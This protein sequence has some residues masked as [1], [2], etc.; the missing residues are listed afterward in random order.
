MAAWRGAVPL[1]P[2]VAVAAGDAGRRARDEVMPEM[3][4][5]L[6]ADLDDQRSTPLA[7]LREAVRYPTSVLAAA[8]VPP[9]PRDEFAVRA[10]P[11]DAYNLTPATWADLDPSLTEAGIAWGAAKAFEH[12]RRHAP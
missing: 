2:E 6:A 12:K 8:G 5:L 9:V 10:F 7:I 3:R 4:S 11:N 1:P